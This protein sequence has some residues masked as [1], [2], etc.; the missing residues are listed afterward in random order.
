MVRFDRILVTGGAGFIGSHLVEALVARGAQVRVLD[1]FWSGSAKNLS[2]VLNQIELIQGDLRDFQLVRSALQD[3]DLVFHLASTAS[4][5]ASIKDPRY[6]LETNVLG[7]LNLLQAAMDTE[8]RMVYTS[9]AAVYGE[10][11]RI[12]IDEE[13]PTNPISPYAASKLAAE[14]IGFGFH[15]TYGIDF[16]AVR[17]FNTY[18]P[19]Q[20]RY[21]LYDWLIKLANDPTKLE[22]LG[23]GNQVRDLCYVSDMVEA[24][25]IA[26]QRGRNQVYNAS[27]QCPIRILDL[28]QLLISKFSPNA[29]IQ[30]TGSSW[31]GDI[32]VLVAEISKLKQLGYS[33]KVKL[34]KGL[35]L[36]IDWFRAEHA[37]AGLSDRVSLR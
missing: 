4:V 29:R 26:A 35:D 19:R 22:V 9:S 15:H 27:G 13:H 11:I 30:C 18:G 23:D 8:L 16:L 5:P 24:L 21:V 36:L 34:D 14:K 17:V 1:N 7:M 31:A 28:A 10:P 32:K 12:P 6:D 20:G 25:L 33:P 37:A 2:Q 3:I